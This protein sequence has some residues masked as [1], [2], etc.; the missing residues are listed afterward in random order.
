VAFLYRN[1][2]QAEN[3]IRETTP[4]T[5]VTNNIN[6]LGL[7]LTKEM[8]DPYDKNSKS[9]KKEMKEDFRR[10]KDLSGSWIGR[11]NIIKMALLLEATY[12]FNSIPIKI[13]TNS[14]LNWKGQF[15]NSSGITKT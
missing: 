13:P 9:L 8:K 5:I 4:F 12:R 7:I 10:W 15:A 2:K 6:Y 11:V 3:K 14:S 1:Y